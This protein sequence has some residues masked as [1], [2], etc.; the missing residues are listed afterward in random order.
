MLLLAQTP[1]ELVMR[2][3]IYRGLWPG[4]INF[5]GTNKP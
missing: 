5:D 1:R 3:I 4:E 2:E